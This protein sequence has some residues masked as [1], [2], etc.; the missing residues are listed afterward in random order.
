MTLLGQIIARHRDVGNN[1]IYRMHMHVGSGNFNIFPVIGDVCVRNA[2]FGDQASRF[3][4]RQRGKLL[5]QRFRIR[6]YDGAFRFIPRF[7][8][9]R[10]RDEHAA[11][12]RALSFYLAA[13]VRFARRQ[14][15]GVIQNFQR[16]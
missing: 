5:L 14:R 12:R 11:D 13:R 10:K 4:P 2:R 3:A 16:G 7:R 8:D 1:F 6:L 15:N 9:H